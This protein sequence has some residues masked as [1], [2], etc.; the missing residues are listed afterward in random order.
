MSSLRSN[1]NI[2]CHQSASEVH[3]IS[4]NETSKAV[5][6]PWFHGMSPNPDTTDTSRP[7]HGTP[8]LSR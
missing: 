5:E 8:G 7:G 3:E 6:R 2:Y 4:A 1:F